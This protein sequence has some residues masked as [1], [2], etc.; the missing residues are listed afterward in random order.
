M[1]LNWLRGKPSRFNSRTKHGMKNTLH[2]RT[3]LFNIL[4]FSYNHELRTERRGVKDNIQSKSTLFIVSS[5]I[6][7]KLYVVLNIGDGLC[8]LIA[9]TFAKCHS[10]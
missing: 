6:R 2:S 4:T 10:T 5:S 8:V 7:G 9:P 1:T 3:Q